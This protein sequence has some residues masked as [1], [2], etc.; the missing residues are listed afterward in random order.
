MAQPLLNVGELI[1]DPDFCQNFQIK[2]REG[3]WNKGRFET[4]EEVIDTYGIIDPQ[5]TKE[6]V[7]PYY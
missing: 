4:T 3:T 7:L 2:R 5:T 6:L 1:T